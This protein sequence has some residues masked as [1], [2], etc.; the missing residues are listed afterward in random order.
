MSDTLYNQPIVIDNGSGNIRAGFAGDDRPKINYSNIIGSPKYTKVMPSSISENDTFIGSK[1]QKLRGLLRLR[2]PI[3]HGVVT[4]WNDMEDIWN[5]VITRLDCKAEEHPLSITEEPLNPRSNRTKMCETL[6]ETFNFPTIHIAM[7]A[8]LSLYSTGRTS[9]TVVDCGDGVTTIAPVYEGF[10]IPGS[11]KRM[12]IGGRDITRYLQLELLRSGYCMSSSSEFEI[13][14]S[15]KERLGFVLPDTNINGVGDSHEGKTRINDF[16]M[17]DSTAKAREFKL[18]DDKVI[19]I[20]EPALSRPCELLFE[21][22]AA[23]FEDIPVQDAI[24]WAITKTD[25]DLRGKLFENIVLSGGST[26]FKNFGTRLLNELLKIN[27]SVKMKIYA[28]P[29]RKIS[30]F[31]GGSILASLSTFKN[32][33]ISKATYLEDPY[34]IYHKFM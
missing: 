25:T 18:P 29:D 8:V 21:P 7:P 1:A 28:S 4:N 6:F 23:G 19:K 12:N 27:K 24:Y 30:C 34:C 10:S 17:Y 32:V 16:L 2:Y 31:V 5:E 9:G 11:I 22:E 15:M 13:V 26:L 14:R 20:S 3:S 33:S